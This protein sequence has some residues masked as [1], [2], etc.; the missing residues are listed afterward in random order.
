VRTE[1]A[2][3]YEAKL[4]AGRK[5]YWAQM[6]LI[7]TSAIVL[8]F[9]G[10]KASR[11]RPTGAEKARRQEAMR[12]QEARATVNEAREE[13]ARAQASFDE[14]I[15]DAIAD[16]LGPSLPL[17]SCAIAMGDAEKLVRGRSMIPLLVVRGAE[18]H[19]WSPSVERA[20]QDVTTAE[21]LLDGVNP[22]SAVIYSDALEANPIDQ[23]L[24]RDVVVVA[25]RWKAPTRAS[26]TAFEPGE[27]DGTAYVFDFASRRM[28]CAGEIHASNSKSLE[29]T[30]NETSD[31]RGLRLD[32]RLEED[33]D[34]QIARSIVE[35]NALYLIH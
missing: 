35:P 23:R 8:A 3:S 33:L 34:R 2:D 17:M 7:F 25:S 27:L 14:A 11:N 10:L 20:S 4:L 6:A 31:A 1:E 29:Y 5:R 22:M 15:H 24:T 9:G 26:V 30:Y 32:Q 18:A 21:A 19:Y 12:V 28:I 13:L 16:R